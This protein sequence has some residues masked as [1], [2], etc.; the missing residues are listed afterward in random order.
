MQADTVM[1]VMYGIGCFLLGSALFRRAAGT[2]GM[3]HP[4]IITLVYYVSIVQFLLPAAL[5]AAGLARGYFSRRAIYED[6]AIKAFYATYSA[7][8]LLPMVIIMLQKVLN[9]HPREEG[10][11]LFNRSWKTVTG[12]SDSSVMFGLVMSGVVLWTLFLGVILF[13]DVPLKHALKGT[14]TGADLAVARHRWTWTEEKWVHYMSN[15]VGR[16]FA[17]L[18]S[19]TSF[20]YWLM[21][22]SPTRL[23]VFFWL[24]GVTGMFLLSQLNKGP[25]VFYLLLP[26]G[27]MYGLFRGGFNSKL[28]A[29][30][31]L[32][33]IIVTVL[34]YMFTLRIADLHIII[35][36]FLERMF[37]GQYSGTVLTFDMFPRLKGFLGLSGFS[38]QG[39]WRLLGYEGTRYSVLLMQQYNPEGWTAERAGYM[40]T[41]FIAEGYAT[42]GV[43]GIVLSV[44]IVAL[45]L[46][47][48]QWLWFRVRLH[49]V[50][51]AFLAL[52][53]FRVLSLLGDGLFVFLYPSEV[54]V[55]T[56]VVC[57]IIL[58]VR[59]KM[60]F[61][62]VR[63]FARE[64]T[65]LQILAARRCKGKRASE[66]K[67][68]CL[69]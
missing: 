7:F 19:L 49:P 20:A 15:I 27:Y 1:V 22:R 12:R 52:F 2:L 28:L 9:L 11:A 14:L 34:L 31:S 16:W 35:P 40:S 66:L 48:L 32:I 41:F 69:D 54:F 39:P 67:D 3:R 37:L 13:T 44:F 60:A 23:I 68:A 47:L 46:S 4:N 50:S 18:A 17:P 42:F 62:L 55:P 63:Y 24:S 56:L 59:G 25:L 8:V 53:S 61:V 30:L 33:S 38:V 65:Q 51:V 5:E 21:R 58:C 29:V 45:W 6:S 43:I 26:A 57:L 10:L 64:S 36:V